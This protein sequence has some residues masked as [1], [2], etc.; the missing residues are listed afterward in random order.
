MQ[1]SSHANLSL[2]MTNGRPLYPMCKAP[3]WSVRYD[4]AKT[5]DDKR[6]FQCPRCDH[7]QAVRFTPKSGH[8]RGN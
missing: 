8:V 6:T 5:V 2:E 1:F 3:M 7:F 4:P